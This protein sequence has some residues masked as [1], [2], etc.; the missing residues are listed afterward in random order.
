MEEL[1]KT[2]EEFAVASEKLAAIEFSEV[3]SDDLVFVLDDIEKALDER[4]EMFERLDA[5][6]AG[7]PNLKNTILDSETNAKLL[8]LRKRITE[9]NAAFVEMYR[10]RKDEV[11]ARL[12]TL[13]N[14]RK[15]IDFLNVN[16]VGGAA[17]IQENKS[18]S[19]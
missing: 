2:L 15:K 12:K 16:T 8:D 5:I 14:N 1:I 9:S 18:F 19:I 3:E 17:N 6:Q 7:L 13:Q 11:K 10:T 4:E